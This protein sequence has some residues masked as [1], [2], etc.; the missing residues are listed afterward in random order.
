MDERFRSVT[1]SL[2]DRFYES[3]RMPGGS[4]HER[5]SGRYAADP[6]LGQAFYQIL[7][8]VSYRLMED[9]EN[10]YGYFFFQMGREIRLDLAGPTGVNFKGAGYVLYFNPLLF[11]ELDQEQ[12]LSAIKH[13]ILHVLSGHLIRAAALKNHLS[14][15]AMNMGMDIVVNSLLSPL[16]PYAVTL[17]SV[18][19]RYFLNM[20]PYE[21][22]EAYSDKI[23][24]AMDLLDERKETEEEAAGDEAMIQIEFSPDRTHDLW[25]ESTEADEEI[26]LEMAR[27]AANQAAKGELPAYIQSLLEGLKGSRE[28]LPWNVYLNRLMGRVESQRRRTVT[29]RDRRQPDR[30]ELRGQLRV[31]KAKILV[32]IDISASI[33]DGEFRQ[34]M[35]EVLA[36][37]KNYNHEITVAECDDEIRRTYPVRREQDLKERLNT[38]GAT[39]FAPVVDYG[40]QSGINLLI[41]FTDGRGEKRLPAVPKGY[42]ILWIISGKGDKLSLDTSYGAVKKLSREGVRETKEEHV[43]VDKGGHSM[44]HHESMF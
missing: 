20:E 6:A 28:E 42:K 22:F 24:I 5:L 12:M 10:F 9:R 19:A 11:L 35:V 44:N 2:R 32:G 18:N 36:I 33:S 41:Y 27:K 17:R 4:G 21:T 31:H 26:M 43:E 30:L 14:R 38:R 37:V 15:G 3:L 39:R 25:E 16:P 23:Q 40:N 34:A 7:D 13:E 8:R 29:R 1:L